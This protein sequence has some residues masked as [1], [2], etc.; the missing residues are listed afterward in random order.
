MSKGNRFTLFGKTFYKTIFISTLHISFSNGIRSG[1]KTATV[2]VII[3]GFSHIED[4]SPF[5]FR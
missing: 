3:V 5:V 1:G 2:Y 4:R